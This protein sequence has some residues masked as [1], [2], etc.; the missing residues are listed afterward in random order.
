MTFI[1]LTSAEQQHYVD[2]FY[3]SYHS[4]WSRNM[5]SI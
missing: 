4:N 3:T 5:E 1:T 2:T